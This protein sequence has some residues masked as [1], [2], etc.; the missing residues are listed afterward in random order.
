[1]KQSHSKRQV[2]VTISFIWHGKSALKTARCH[3]AKIDVGYVSL[4]RDKRK[5]GWLSLALNRNTEISALFSVL[6]VPYV[7]GYAYLYSWNLTLAR[8]VL[9]LRFIANSRNWDA[10]QR[11]GLA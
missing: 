5:A 4:M 11:Y 8:I 3:F 2:A 6:N 1:M 7:S 9:Q 10:T